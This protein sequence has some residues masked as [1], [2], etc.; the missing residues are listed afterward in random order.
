MALDSLAL[1]LTEHGDRWTKKERKLYEKA[2]A[3]YEEGLA[4]L[5]TVVR[6]LICWC[7]RDFLLTCLR[8]YATLRPLKF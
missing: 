6:R 4:L 8:S 2:V 5:A 1:A 3:G 7:E